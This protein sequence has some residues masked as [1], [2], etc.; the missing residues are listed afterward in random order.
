[1]LMRAVIIHNKTDIEFIGN[2]L[3]NLLQ[4]DEKFLV[5]VSLFRACQ[6]LASCHIQCRKQGCRTM[7]NVM[8]DSTIALFCCLHVFAKLFADWDRHHL[9]PSPCQR[10]PRRAGKLSLGE[11]RFIMV[12]FHISAYKDFKHFRFYGLSQEYGNCSED[13]PSYSRFVSLKP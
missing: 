10:Q 12:L 7:T 5:P 8:T 9:I 13:L 4:E 11:M 2:A 6:H 3:V 1:M